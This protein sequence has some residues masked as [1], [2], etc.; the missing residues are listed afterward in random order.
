M[1]KGVVPN[2]IF[3][4]RF[5]GGRPV[6]LALLGV[7]GTN[8]VIRFADFQVSGGRAAQCTGRLATGQPFS[9]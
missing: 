9:R 4:F 8:V 2:Y 1:L 6:S 5:S 3:P 7:V